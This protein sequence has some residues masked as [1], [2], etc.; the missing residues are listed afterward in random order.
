MLASLTKVAIEE[1]QAL[2]AL[3]AEL[4]DA[5]RLDDWLKLYTDDMTYLVPTPECRDARRT[6]ACS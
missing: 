3:E 2:V 5:W 1:A 4:L 6:R